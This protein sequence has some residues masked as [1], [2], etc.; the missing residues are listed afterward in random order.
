M[1]MADLVEQMFQEGAEFHEMVLEVKN[2]PIT[3]RMTQDSQAVKGKYG[4]EA[5]TPEGNPG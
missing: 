2:K 1:A 5:H 3:K 4:K